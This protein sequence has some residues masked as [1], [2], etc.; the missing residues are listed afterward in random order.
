M[1]SGGVPSVI[2]EPEGIRLSHEV[3]DLNIIPD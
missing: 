2:D 1:L 3:L